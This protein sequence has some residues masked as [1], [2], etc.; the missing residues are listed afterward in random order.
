MGTYTL[1][2]RPGSVDH[3]NQS[4][5]VTLTEDGEV[6]MTNV[7]ARAFG[8]VVGTVKRPDG[9]IPNV[10]SN[11]FN[12]RAGDTYVASMGIDGTATH[13]DFVPPACP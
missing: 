5:Q 1:S 7:V 9:S 13:A 4:F 12:V 2:V 11:L 3:L 10:V 6:S 8:R